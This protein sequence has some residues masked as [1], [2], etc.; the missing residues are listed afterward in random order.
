MHSS[1]QVAS[2]AEHRGKG[3]GEAVTLAALQRLRDL[4]NQSCWLETDDWRIPAIKIY[5][6]CLLDRTS[7]LICQFVLH[8]YD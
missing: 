4:G 1:E 5:F 3:L 7:L 2:I 8:S 6:K